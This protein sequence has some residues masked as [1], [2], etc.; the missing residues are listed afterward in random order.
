MALDKKSLAGSSVPS[1]LNVLHSKLP[2][3]NH[4]VSRK[5]TASIILPDRRGYFTYA[6]KSFPKVL[7]EAWIGFMVVFNL[8][9]DEWKPAGVEVWNRCLGK[10]TNVSLIEYQREWTE[11]VVRYMPFDNPRK[12]ALKRIAKGEHV[13]CL[14]CET[15]G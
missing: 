7:L 15:R 8:L 4:P 3:L 10:I 9:P 11:G 6:P 2:K 13:W 12:R 1:L 5:V 14:Q